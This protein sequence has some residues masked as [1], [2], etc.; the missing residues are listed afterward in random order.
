MYLDK[1]K[2]GKKQRFWSTAQTVECFIPQFG[3]Y[4]PSNSIRLCALISVH[5]AATKVSHKNDSQQVSSCQYINSLITQFTSFHS[6]KGK[7]YNTCSGKAYNYIIHPFI[8]WEVSQS[9]FWNSSSVGPTDS[10]GLMI[11]RPSM[12]NRQPLPSCVSLFLRRA[13][14]WCLQ[15]SGT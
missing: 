10:V 8:Y 13:M 12:I 7:A 14:V 9:Y 1:N 11:S 15:S 4:A 5:T 2:D 3:S 6:E